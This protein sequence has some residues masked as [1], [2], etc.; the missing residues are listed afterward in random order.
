MRDTLKSISYFEEYLEN[1][2]RK[3]IKYKM[4]AEKV[5]E[6]RGKEDEGLKRAY[7]IIQNSY[8]NKLNGLY[9][10]GAPIEEIKLLYPE[11]IEIMN[12]VWNKESGYVRLLWMLSIGIMIDVPQNY[13]NQL[14]MLVEESQLNDYLVD[15]LFHYKNDSWNSSSKQFMFSD[16][17]SI[18]YDA[19]NAES[20]SEGLEKLKYYLE[21]KWYQGHNDTGW[22]DSHE[23][24]HNTYN[25]YWS[26]ES[27][28]IAKILKLDD[29]ALKDTPYYPYDMV[30]YKEK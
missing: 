2:N 1:E 29:S 18:L 4:M 14:Q 30:H 25:G 6:E 16:P 17:Y 5:R 26:F 28:A 22:H 11:I 8:F 13:I 3:I 27:G 24:K 9:S 12:K 10:M 19:I 21:D 7:I 23:S 15:Y 20:K